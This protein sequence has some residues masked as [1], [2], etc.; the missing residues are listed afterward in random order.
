MGSTE[1]TL[2]KVCTL[3][4]EEKPA[5]LEFFVRQKLG[6]YGLRSMC[7]PCFARHRKTDI[8]QFPKLSDFPLPD[9][10]NPLPLSIQLNE[11]YPSQ[12]FG[13]YLPCKFS[14]VRPGGFL[15]A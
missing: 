6:K 10:K 5:T 3:C 4:K 14:P 8:L 7:K 2:S 15:L 13:L 1:I 9:V 12:K 11:A